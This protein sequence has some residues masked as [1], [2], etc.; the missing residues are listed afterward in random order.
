MELTH[1]KSKH[2]VAAFAVLSKSYLALD[3]LSG[4]GASHVP[5]FE[6]ERHFNLALLPFLS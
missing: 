6:P 4:L 1:A 3:F 2:F 5:V